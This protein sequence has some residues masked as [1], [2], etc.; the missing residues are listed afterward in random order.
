MKTTVTELPESR[1]RVEAEVEPAEVQKRVDQAA[2]AIGRDLRIPGFRKGKVPP[3]VIIS[4]VGRE[5]VVDQ[6]VRESL[7]LWYVAAVDDAG[8]A[9]IGD[10]QLDLPETMP[11]E[12]E[13]LTFSF[14][15]AVRPQAQLGEYKEL[16]VGRRIPDVGD[17]EIDAEVEQLRERLARLDTHEGTAENGDFVVM[18]YVGS[19]D[20]EEFEGGAGRDQLLELGSGRLIPGFEEQL[21]GAAAG[22]HRTVE[23][24]FPADY[25][26]EH[27]A[28]KDAVFEVDVKEVKRKQLPDLDDEFA[29]EAAGFDSLDELRAD[30]RKRLE[31][32]EEQAID[33]EYREAVVDA[34]VA[35]A[36]VDVPQPLIDARAK[37][38]WDNMLHSL[39]HQGINKDAYLSIAQKSEEEL[40]DE[41][42]PDAEQALRRE[43]VLTAVVEAEKLEISDDEV[44]EALTESAERGNV[45][46]KKLLD[47]LRSEGR[48]DAVKEDMAARKAV[49][50]V[51]DT[52]K[53]IEPGLE[54]ARKKLWTPGS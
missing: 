7:G 45:K 22:E 33:R 34:A 54:E 13:A 1:V 47:R 53:P 25:N 52:A 20:G 44:L 14:E 43:A 4:R 18:D 38:L 12:G 48:L 50:L 21:T 49:D 23:V 9:T 2:R 28:G 29:V 6:A 36:T 39:S 42:K 24:A 15:I 37:E 32:A 8:V 41:A 40:L 16:E 27:L 19:I 3:P 11:G 46:P 31:E 5:A 35:N 30:I 51:V 26:A 10:P 17:A